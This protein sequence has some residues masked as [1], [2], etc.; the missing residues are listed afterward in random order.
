[1]AGGVVSEMSN[2]NLRYYAPVT[3]LGWRCVCFCSFARGERFVALGEWCRVHDEAGNHV[4]YQ[5]RSGRGPDADVIAS[6]AARG[7]ITAAESMINAGTYFSGGRSRTMR[8]AEPERIGRVHPLDGRP[9]PAEDRAERV[10]QKVKD[11]LLPDGRAVLAG[12]AS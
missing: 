11:W 5:Q 6:A 9:L 8:L 7:A 10:M 2:R 3:T 1:M 12:R 4:G